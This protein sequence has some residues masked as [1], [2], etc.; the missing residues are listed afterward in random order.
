[1]IAKPPA[2][3]ELTSLSVVPPATCPYQVGQKLNTAGIVV[4]ALYNKGRYA[5]TVTGSASFSGFTSGKVGTVSVKVSYAASGV[6]KSASFGCTIVKATSSVGVV[7]ST[8]TIHKAKTRAV[9]EAAVAT[10]VPG[11]VAYGKVRFYLDGK[12]LTTVTLDTDDK[13]LTTLKLPRI[14][15]TGTHTVEVRYLG[16]S[17]LVAAK[18]TLTVKVVK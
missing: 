1:M 2:K 13:G 3:A 14:G 5:K 9:V 18:Q 6:S 12:R 17:K 16:N 8:K 11:V 10:S 4:I 7:L 15:K